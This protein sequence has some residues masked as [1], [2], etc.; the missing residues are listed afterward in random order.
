M[1]PYFADTPVR[2]VRAEE[3][4]LCKACKK[5]TKHRYEEISFHANVLFVKVFCYKKR[6]T[7]ICS[8]CHYGEELD[9]EQFQQEVDRLLNPGIYSGNSTYSTPPARSYDS[10]GGTHSRP[11]SSRDKEIDDN[12]PRYKISV[13]KGMKFCREC[14]Q[15]IF[16]DI[17]YCTS[18][19][20]RGSSPPEPK[21]TEPKKT[22]VKGRKKRK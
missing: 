22:G 15:K 21:K 11:A 4:R 9:Q 14:G 18:C 20:V 13:K 6:F 17:G 16:P 2:E 3:I 12:L 19:A 10:S 5:N 8:S 7:R 1:I